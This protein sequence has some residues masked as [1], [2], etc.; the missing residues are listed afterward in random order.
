MGNIKRL[1]E[2]NAK[3]LLRQKAWRDLEPLVRAELKKYGDQLG[4]SI[5]DAEVKAKPDMRKYGLREFNHGGANLPQTLAI[6]TERW[7]THPHGTE[8]Q[9]GR[10]N[11]TQVVQC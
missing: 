6:Q 11:G 1:V 3:G 2:S 9:G 10:Q 7:P 8:Q 5:V 4:R